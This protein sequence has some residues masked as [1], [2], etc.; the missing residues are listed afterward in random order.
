[1][2]GDPAFAAAQRAW[3][4]GRGPTTLPVIDNEAPPGLIAAAREMAAP[5]RE[6]HQP[7]D[8]QSGVVPLTCYECS[9]VWPCATARLVYAEEELT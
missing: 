4:D 5:I 3:D 2:S 6:L 1:M 7:C 8:M 9:D